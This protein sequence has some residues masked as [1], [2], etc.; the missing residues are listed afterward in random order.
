MAPQM[1]ATV[2]C[3]SVFILFLFVFPVFCFSKTISF[4]RDE[5]LNIRQNTPQNLLPDFDYSDV[6]LDIVVGGAVALVK[7]FRTRRWGKRAGALVKLRQ[8]GFRTPLPS[9]H[10]VN[11]RSLPNKTDELLLL[12]RTNKDFSNSAVL[13]FTET[14]LNDAIT[15]SVLHLPNFQLIRADRDAESTGK[16]RGGGTCFYINERWCTDVTVLK[17]C[18]SDLETLFINCKPFYSPREIC[19]FILVRV[20]IPSQAHARSAVQKLADQ[21]TDTEQQHPDSVLII[22]GDF[23]KAN[24]SRELPKYRQHITCPTRDS[25]LLDHCYTAIKDAYHSVPRAALGLS[26]HCLVHPIPTYRQKLKSA[27]P[28]LRT[29]KRWT[30][31]AEQ[32]LK[33]CFDLTD[34]TVFEAAANDLGELTKTVTSVSVKIC[35][36]LPG[37]I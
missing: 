34:C 27:K 26:D 31:E 14:W 4:T 23:N 12:T 5:L 6:L 25:N 7:R 20:Y 16:S 32:D 3:S 18:C 29:V 15:D 37:L 8:R 2:L 19:S 1:A 35:V 9:I 10:L 28:V 24:L 36:F 11:L 13:C 17:M 30:N 21:I 22:L 33:A